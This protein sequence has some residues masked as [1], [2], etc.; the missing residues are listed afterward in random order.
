MP[1]SDPIKQKEAQRAHYLAHK[2]LYAERAKAYKLAH[3]EQVR[4]WKLNEAANKRRKDAELKFIKVEEQKKMSVEQTYGNDWYN[5]CRAWICQ[6]VSIKTKDAKLNEAFWTILTAK[7]NKAIEDNHY[8][9]RDAHNHQRK[10]EDNTDGRP[11]SDDLSREPN[12]LGGD[13]QD[14]TAEQ[15][16][17]DLPCGEYAEA[18]E[19]VC[20][21]ASAE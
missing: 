10:Y 7:V 14:D 19:G 9:Y 5:Q 16:E 13:C 4:Q 12:Q 3:P 18:S 21:Q 17:C 8:V 2:A 15:S 1:Y 6:G 11:R 20:G